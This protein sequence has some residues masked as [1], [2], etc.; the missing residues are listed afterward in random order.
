MDDN[1]LALLRRYAVTGDQ[2]AFTGLV[3]RY[4]DLVYSAA[5]RQVR[6]AALAQDVAQAVF[7]DL[8][9]HAGRWNPDVPVVAWLYTVTRRKAID[10]LRRETARQARERTAA[11][12]TLVSTDD[13]STHAEAWPRLAAALDEAMLALNERDRRAL[14]L[15]FFQNRPLRDIGQVLGVS[16]DAAQKRVTR[17]LNQLRAA[18]TRR[19]IAIG[20]TSL[21]AALSAHAVQVAPASVS[22]AI[23]T[24]FSTATA[25]TAL[26]PAAQTLTT[27]TMTTLQKTLLTAAVAASLTFGG[28]HAHRAHQHE[29]RL[30]SLEHALA[31]ADATRLAAEKKLADAQAELRATDATLANADDL[32]TS[33]ARASSG[34][35]AALAADIQAWI[36][37]VQELKAWSKRLP[38][39]TIPEMSLLKES[40]WL[41]VVREDKIENEQQARRALDQI[42]QTAKKRFAPMMAEALRN[43]RSANADALPTSVQELAPYLKSPEAVACLQ[44]YHIAQDDGTNQFI[45]ESSRV[46]DEYDSQIK[47]FRNG[48]WGQSTATK[49]GETVSRALAAYQ[50]AN[51]GKKPAT[52]ADLEPYLRAAGAP[53]NTIVIKSPN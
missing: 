26:A 12:L 9:Q 11:E 8:S 40:D 47:I 46:D 5:L 4:V 34:P 30:R 2:A 1:D 39:L 18:F 32:L 45:V 53:P 23:L 6:S 36:T 38:A 37:R 14:L 17:A 41:H 35:D 28:Y 27:L 42:R 49:K 33:L 51:G 31:D 19:G 21:G 50:K 43:Y 22:N 3:S 25:L 52:Q 16:D 29:Q 48:G 44:R 10:A 7:L 24:T 15:R 13:P 20:A